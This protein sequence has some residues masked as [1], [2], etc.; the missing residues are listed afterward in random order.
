[1]YF[2]YLLMP[3]LITTAA[4]GFQTVSSYYV[5]S[6]LAACCVIQAPIRGR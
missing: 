4:K 6:L 3:Q 5:A 1:M 2:G